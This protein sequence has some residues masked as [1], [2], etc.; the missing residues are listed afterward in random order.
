VYNNAPPRWAAEVPGVPPPPS[1]FALAAGGR[2]A[3]F[4]FVSPM[5]VRL[6]PGGANKVLWAVDPGAGADVV[7]RIVA[8]REGHGRARRFSAAAGDSNGRVFRTRLR[9]SRPGCWRLALRWGVRHA[10]LDVAVR[11]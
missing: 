6:P 4:L 5:R 2:A 8:R 3:A 1:A 11:P 9:F 10:V 7:L